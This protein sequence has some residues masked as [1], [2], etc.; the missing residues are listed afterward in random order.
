[1]QVQQEHIRWKSSN[2]QIVKGKPCGD[3]PCNPPF[4][5]L[6]YC[7]HRTQTQALS[8]LKYDY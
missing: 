4:K 8:A 5:K 3:T 6:L 1:M 2:S 7:A